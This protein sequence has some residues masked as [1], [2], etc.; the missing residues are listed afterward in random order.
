VHLSCLRLFSEFSSQT[1]RLQVPIVGLE[2]LDLQPLLQRCDVCRQIGCGVSCVRHKCGLGFHL[3]CVRQ[4][5]LSIELRTQQGHDSRFRVYC[6]RHRPP[7]LLKAIEQ[8]RKRS[9]EEIY[10]FCRLVQKW[11]SESQP[12]DLTGQQ[13]AR[14]MILSKYCRTL[15]V[16]TLLCRNYR[17]NYP[18]SY[19]RSRT[20]RTHPIRSCN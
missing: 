4:V 19:T 3:E 2:S 20:N 15:S 16:D 7:R 12:P 18:T 17:T 6:P 1:K 11:D 5:G 14:S 9:L 10:S 13:N 8:S